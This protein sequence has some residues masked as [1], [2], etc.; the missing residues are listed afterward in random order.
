[1]CNQSLEHIEGRIRDVSRP[2]VPPT[3]SLEHKLDIQLSRACGGVGVTTITDLTDRRL[4][5]RFGG[6]IILHLNGKTSRS[7]VRQS[8]S[9]LRTYWKP[10]LGKEDA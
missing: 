8:E 9:E 1:M 2:G 7:A 4:L 10:L 6:G 5:P 3:T